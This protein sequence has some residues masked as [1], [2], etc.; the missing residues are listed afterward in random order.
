MALACG[1]T[2]VLKSLEMCPATHRLI[3]LCFVDAGLPA[4]AVNVISN[5]PEDAAAIVKALIEAP[6]AKHVNFTGSTKVGRIIGRL[7]G[8]ALK[9]SILALGGKSPLAIRVANDTEYGLSSAVFSRNILRA[10][11]VANRIESGNCPIN[12]PTVADEAQMPF[13][14]VKAS[15][16]VRFG[17]KA[18]IAAFSELR[19]IAIED[20]N[21]H[22][23]FVQP[24][25]GAGG[26]SA[27]LPPRE[28]YRHGLCPRV[29]KAT[30]QVISVTYGGGIRGLL[31]LCT[32]WS[33][34]PRA[35]ACSHRRASNMPVSAPSSPMMGRTCRPW[36]KPLPAGRFADRFR[37]YTMLGIAAQAGLIGQCA[38]LI[39][40]N[41]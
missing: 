27:N 33:G 11:A 6:A 14:G 31:T 34:R 28:S 16:F 22:Y 20:P 37:Q 39:G 8:E 9:P 5:A 24:A 35:I 32:N 2:V 36:I 25:S 40:G 12:G 3:G 1:N 41:G 18:A 21:Q 17:G 26:G 4:G 10:M 7:A 19:W 30:I 38:T 15:G 29:D 13:G 23:P